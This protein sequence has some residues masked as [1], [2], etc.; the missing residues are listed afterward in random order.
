MDIWDHTYKG[1]R[2]CRISG[3]YDH[4]TD[5]V[6]VHVFVASNK[7]FDRHENFYDM[8]NTGLFRMSRCRAGFGWYCDLPMPP[9]LPE[10]IEKMV[11][12]QIKGGDWQPSS[13]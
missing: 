9:D 2:I 10:R 6:D 5:E 3:R 1:E 7:L 12:E 11:I 13:V 4:L 8:P